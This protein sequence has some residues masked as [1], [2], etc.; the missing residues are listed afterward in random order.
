MDLERDIQSNKGYSKADRAVLVA[1]QK[2]IGF[3]ILIRFFFNVLL[4]YIHIIFKERSDSFFF[5][6]TIARKVTDSNIRLNHI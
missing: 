1:F 4:K 3:Y 6:R 2:T 5:K